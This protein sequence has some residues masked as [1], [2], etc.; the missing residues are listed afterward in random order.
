MH[1][2]VC[3]LIEQLVQIQE[4]GTK[5]QSLNENTHSLFLGCSLLLGSCL[6]LG[7]SLLLRSHLLGFGSSSGLFLVVSTELVRT[8]IC[9]KSPSATAFFSAFKNMPFSHFLS[10]GRLACMCFLIAMDE[11][12]VR[13]LSSVMAMIIPALYD[14]VMID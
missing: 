14:I 5:S 6:L 3:H 8:L 7:C 13:S 10:A 12:P 1:E 9:T 11:E 2:D 4:S